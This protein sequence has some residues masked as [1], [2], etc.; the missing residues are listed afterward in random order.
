MPPRAYHARRDRYEVSTDSARLDVDV[1]HDFLA[2]SYW[3]PGIPR[4]TVERAIAGSLNFGLYANGAQIGFARVV[5]DGATYAYLADVFVL[6]AHRGAGLGVWLVEC[7]LA[8]PAL[9]GLRRFALATRNAHSLYAR[10]GFTAL[11]HPEYQ[12]EISR[13]DLYRTPGG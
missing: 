3:S 12:M 8:H 7:V 2:S 4:E 1:I 13:P 9:A 5:T 6:P 10:F 11:A